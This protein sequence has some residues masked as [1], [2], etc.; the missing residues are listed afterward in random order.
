MRFS[1]IH[2]QATRPTPIMFCGL[3]M[4]PDEN[5]TTSSGTTATNRSRRRA[6][7]FQIQGTRSGSRPDRRSRTTRKTAAAAAPQKRSG[8][9]ADRR[10]AES[11]GRSLDAQRLGISPGGAGHGGERK[12]EDEQEPGGRPTGSAPAE[13][14]QSDHEDGR[15]GEYPGAPW[16][17]RLAPD[18]RQVAGGGRLQDGAR[19]HVDGRGLDLPESRLCEAGQPHQHRRHPHHAPIGEIEA[20]PLG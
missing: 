20:K 9:T 3:W 1:R 18:P 4:P 2:C 6:A 14:E 8:P 17:T 11:E 5:R 7:R 10:N 12:M 19:R 16:P 13:G 15:E